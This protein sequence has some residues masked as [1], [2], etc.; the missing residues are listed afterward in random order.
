[1]QNNLAVVD[2]MSM[3]EDELLDL[4]RDR[5]RDA[6]A[7]LVRRHTPAIRKAATGVLRDA[8][9]AEDEVQNAW[10]KAWQHIRGFQ[11]ES[12][13]STWLTRIVLNECLMRLR[14]SSRAAYCYLDSEIPGLENLRLDIPDAGATPEAAIARAEVQ[15]LVRHEIS[16][17]PSLLRQAL[18]L[19]E[20]NQLPMPEV[21]ERL[22]I[23]VAAAKSRL[24]RARIE[25][26]NR[27]E[28]YCGGLGPAALTA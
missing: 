18:V 3:S 14:Q 19:R 13:F 5:N 2:W 7:E 1:M 11:G 12:R 10:C 25:L 20:L 9:A 8:D 6:F 15:D 21:A 16:R 4:A 22:G 23:S 28:K 27:L 17:I 26:R 24:L